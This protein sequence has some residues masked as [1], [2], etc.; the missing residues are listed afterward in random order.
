MTYAV[1]SISVRMQSIFLKNSYKRGIRIIQ[2]TSAID[3][4]V[5]DKLPEIRRCAL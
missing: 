2:I 1:V 4:I 3:Q 5:K